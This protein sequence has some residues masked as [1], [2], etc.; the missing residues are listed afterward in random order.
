MRKFLPL[1]ALRPSMAL[2]ET[3]HP[4]L[5]QVQS[6]TAQ[7]SYAL[8]CIGFIAALVCAQMLVRRR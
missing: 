7:V 2:T 8:G 1:L 5:R 6:A 4:P 3:F